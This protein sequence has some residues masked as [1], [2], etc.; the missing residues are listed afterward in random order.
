[1]K[2]IQIPHYHGKQDEIILENISQIKDFQIIADIFKL[3]SDSTRIKIF[4]ILCHSEKCVLDIS[5]LMNMTSAAISHHLKQLKN[6]HLVISERIGKEVYYK[7]A[8]TNEAKFLHKSIE[9]L[10]NIACP[11]KES[12]I[13]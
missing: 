10:L 7:A 13:L 8:D 12:E 1:M 6:S 4:W 5:S 11:K 9:E 3:L 2:H